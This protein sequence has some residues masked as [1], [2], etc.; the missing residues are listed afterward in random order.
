MPLSHSPFVLPLLP[1]FTLLSVCRAL[2]E[3]SPKN[4]P[5]TVSLLEA[6]QDDIAHGH[7]V[8]VP[9]IDSGLASMPLTGRTVEHPLGVN[10]TDGQINKETM[11]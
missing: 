10:C 1:P 4:P 6:G 3:T 2:C 11:T 5:A 9:F 8:T 7:G